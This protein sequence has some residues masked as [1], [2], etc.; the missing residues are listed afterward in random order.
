MPCCHLFWLDDETNVLF[1]WITKK[2]LT[3]HN[4][5]NFQ[6][7]KKN[8]RITFLVV[9]EKKK[10]LEECCVIFLLLGIFYFSLICRQ[11]RCCYKASCSYDWRWPN[12]VDL[13]CFCFCCW[14][15]KRVVWA[16]ETQKNNILRLTFVSQKTTPLAYRKKNALYTLPRSAAAVFLY[17]F[18]SFCRFSR[19]FLPFS[20]A[21]HLLLQLPSSCDDAHAHICKPCAVAL[22]YMMLLIVRTKKKQ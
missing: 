1:I 14:E 4:F 20:C 10:L 22:F 11:Y 18:F 5:Q 16:S 19:L 2:R 9:R 6:S 7:Q 17:R 21:L 8:R 3:L 12:L 15:E 13:L